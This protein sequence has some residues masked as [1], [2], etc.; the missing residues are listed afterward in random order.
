MAAFAA[1]LDFPIAVDR[2]KD[3]CAVRH[4]IHSFGL[5]SLHVVFVFDLM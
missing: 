3:A 1:N 2:E 5:V 4:F